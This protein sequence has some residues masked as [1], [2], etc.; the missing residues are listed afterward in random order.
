MAVLGWI[1]AYVAAQALA[2]EVAPYVPVGEPGSGLRHA[3]AFSLVFLGALV[4]WTL[5]ASLVRLLIHATPL[6]A[7]DRTLG[8]GFGLLRGLLALLV[9]ATVVT[10][11]PAREAPQWTSSLGA[12]WLTGM[13][14]GLKPMLP[15]E[16]A[17]HLRI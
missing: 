8:A 11:T 5:G 16:L 10:M 7:A 2:L 3:V 17:G 9:L 12:Q 6:S 15:H 4:V 1:A 13:L 14:Q